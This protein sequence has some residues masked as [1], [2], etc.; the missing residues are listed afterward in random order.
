MGVIFLRIEGP[1]RDMDLI[2]EHIVTIK[3]AERTYTHVL[4]LDV[5]Q[6]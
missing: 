2:N 4:F 5:G 1:P 6:S 3:N